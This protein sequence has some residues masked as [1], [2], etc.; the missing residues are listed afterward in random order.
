[1]NETLKIKPKEYENNT[2][3][4]K[5]IDSFKERNVEDQGLNEI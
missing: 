5:G 4:F 2:S 1:M 3:P